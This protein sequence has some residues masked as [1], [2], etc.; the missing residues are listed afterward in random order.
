M[1]RNAT[2][3]ESQRLKSCGAI[4][5]FGLYGLDGSVLAACFALFG[6]SSGWD[7][8]S[9][10]SRAAEAGKPRRG[11]TAQYSVGNRSFL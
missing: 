8:L 7:F 5:S 2:L 9:F 11:H 3:R 4:Y 1:A 6:A 10:C